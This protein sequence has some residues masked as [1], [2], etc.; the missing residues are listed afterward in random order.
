MTLSRALGLSLLTALPLLIACGGEEPTSQVGEWNEQN[1]ELAG[2]A[3]QALGADVEGA[4]EKRCQNCHSVS[5]AKIH[6]WSE[7]SKA[8]N[9]AGCTPRSAR[10]YTYQP[11][12]GNEFTELAELNPDYIDPA[13]DAMSQEDALALVNCM[14]SEPTNPASTFD[15]SKVGIESIRAHERNTHYRR[16]FAKAFPDE[17]EYEAQLLELVRRVKM[18]RGSFFDD[19]LPEDTN[20]EYALAL[21]KEDFWVIREWFD[22]GTPALEEALPEKPGPTE[23][24][25]KITDQLK[26]LIETNARNGWTFKNA[27]DG[28][29]MYGCPGDTLGGYPQTAIDCLTSH[30][31]MPTWAASY[32]GN[33]A[34]AKIRLL[35]ELDFRTSFWT[36][37]SADGRFVGNGK[38]SGSG[39]V[40]TD[41]QNNIDI[42]VDAN[43]DPGFLPDNST[44]VFQGTPVGA[45]F[46][47]Q[48]MLENPPMV[49][50]VLQTITFEENGCGGTRNIRL[51]QHLGTALEGG[52]SFAANGDYTS[53]NGGQSNT[54]KNPSATAGPAAEVTI[55]A[56]VRNGIGYDFLESVKR[57]TPYEGDT[58][59]SPTSAAISSRIAG[60]EGKMLGVNVRPI[61]LQPSGG[62]YAIALGEPSSVCIDG[63][64]PSHS[65]D[66]RYMAIH[67]YSELDGEGKAD[68]YVV[69][70]WDGETHQ[71]TNMPKGVYA[72][73]PHFRSDGWL[74]FAIRDTTPEGDN[75]E[76]VAASD[77][78]LRIELNKPINDVAW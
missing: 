18:P 27:V 76:S 30:T 44:F 2:L 57:N 43:Y 68:I 16:L 9:E 47:P 74:Y 59:I 33:A 65:Y 49:D 38:S 42:P 5:R 72:L 23:C 14:R 26:E 21:R 37:S 34:G 71:V 70:L 62:S 64:K 48:D 13:S 12:G 19:N 73:F 15:P 52:V 31:E 1:A 66:D 78:T 51:Y 10:R 35:T 32:A 29:A 55:T 20:E 58:V 28:V 45:G 17:A 36:R 7:L 46:C 11:R 25:P 54:P 63:G 77:I 39:S 3:L 53:D 56:I 22:R 50:G 60:P 6:D 40:I 67:T 61:T 8:A 75:E 24:V 41:L 69:D 4:A